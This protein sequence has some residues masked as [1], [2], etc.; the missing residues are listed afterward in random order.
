MIETYRS[1]AQAAE[2]SRQAIELARR[3]GWTDEP[4]AG[5]AY[6]MLGAALAWQGRIEEAEP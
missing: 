5:T 2:R 3:H 1:F 4:T 6:V